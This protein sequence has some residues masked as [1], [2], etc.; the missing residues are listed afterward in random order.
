MKAKSRFC[1]NTPNI[2]KKISWRHIAHS[3]LKH[4]G[5]PLRDSG[6]I[7]VTLLE[8]ENFVALVMLLCAFIHFYQPLYLFPIHSFIFAFYSI[9]VGLN[10]LI[11]GCIH[12]FMRSKADRPPTDSKQGCVWRCWGYRND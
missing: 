1:Q 3:I 2:Y 4:S 10:A 5:L 9:S 11:F 8:R 12:A 7:S 6:A